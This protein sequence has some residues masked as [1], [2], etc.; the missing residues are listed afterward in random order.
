M[1]VLN[2]GLEAM[3]RLMNRPEAWDFEGAAELFTGVD[4]GT[5]SLVAVVVDEL[6]RPRAA[7]LR[8][9]EVVKSGLVVD[10][11]GAREIVGELV[12]ELRAAAPKPLEKGATSYPPQTEAGNL[13]TTR[14]LL[15]AAGLTVLATL[16]EPSAANLVLKLEEGA[17]VDV[18]G[19][20]TGIAVM[21]G[22]RVVYSGDE[23]TGGLHLSLVLAGGMKIDL[24]EAERLK[25]DRSKAAQV[26]ALVGPVIDKISS[27]VERHLAP[28]P[29]VETIQMVG[30]T[31][32]LEGLCE[33]VGRNLGRPTA[34]PFFPQAVTPLGVALSCLGNGNGNSK[35]GDGRKGDG[36]P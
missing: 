21:K 29:E 24:E 27:I 5:H 13:Q 30:G 6:G 4:V 15:E 26:L 9:A 14:H 31:C 28:F 11:V 8:L 23:P 17:I 2:Q 20:T 1:P 7:N 25:K 12:E 35:Q 32:E 19:G 33:L 16:D 22:G 34:K 10:Y 18:G 36:R 3:G